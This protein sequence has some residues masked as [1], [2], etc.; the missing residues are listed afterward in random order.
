MDFRLSPLIVSALFTA[1]AL[2]ISLP[3]EALIS[4]P[5]VKNKNVTALKDLIVNVAASE[6][7]TSVPHSKY[8][9]AKMQEARDRAMA[10]SV[11][12]ICPGNGK[13][14]PKGTGTTSQ[15]VS[16]FR[17]D[18]VIGP[19]HAILKEKTMQPREN[20]SKCKAQSV[21]DPSVFLNVKLLDGEAGL[22]AAKDAGFL[23]LGTRDPESFRD[24]AIIQLERP[25]PSAK[26]Y[27][28]TSVIPVHACKPGYADCQSLIGF[29]TKASKSPPGIPKG[30]PFWQTQ[31]VRRVRQ[32]F[33]A[34]TLATDS[35]AFPGSSGT[36]TFLKNEFGDIV[37]DD[38]GQPVPV[39][40]FIGAKGNDGAQF[41][42]QGAEPNQKYTVSLVFDDKIVAEAQA[43]AS[44]KEIVA[45]RTTGTG[46][47]PVSSQ[48][49]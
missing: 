36:I 32:D 3:N 23:T 46:S 49:N 29:S 18:L 12:L 39:G 13:S 19:G 16:V 7:D 25:I 6:H 1:N 34:K 17:G 35:T 22:K 27:Q 30:E 41:Q 2:A 47:L 21:A 20:L 15:F 9:E 14:G 5:C 8:N 42:D 10:N 11:N 43:M 40:F 4:K 38:T 44:K 33:G 48:S 26:P 24:Y 45:E 31:P 28:I 37:S